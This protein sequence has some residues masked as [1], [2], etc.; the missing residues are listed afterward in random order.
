MATQVFLPGELRGQRSLVG[1]IQSMGSSINILHCI[2]LKNIFSATL[3]S[4]NFLQQLRST[5]NSFSLVF[6][7]VFWPFDCLCPST[8]NV[9]IFNIG[10]LLFLVLVHYDKC[11]FYDDDTSRKVKDIYFKE[12]VG[13]LHCRMMQIGYLIL[14]TKRSPKRSTLENSTPIIL[15]FVQ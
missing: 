1:Y 4:S 11:T 5:Y 3:I 15:L 6:W 13:L 7:F 12:D 14:F 8:L 2:P 10:T 9:F